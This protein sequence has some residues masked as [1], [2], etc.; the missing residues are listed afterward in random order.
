MY[1]CTA[2]SGGLGH[3]RY[4]RLYSRIRGFGTH[5]ICTFVQPIQGVWDTHVRLYSR[6]S[7]V[8]TRKISTFVQP[9]Q[10]VWDTQNMYVCTADSEV[11]NAQDTYL[12]PI[13]AFGT[14]M[15]RT[16]VQ[17]I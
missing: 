6:F 10:G 7:G 2:E 11:W 3:T 15:I 14:P 12:E 13:Q 9:I 4:V 8:G 5:K 17:P 1:V 16:Y